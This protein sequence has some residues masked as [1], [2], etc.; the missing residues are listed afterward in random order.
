M[1]TILLGIADVLASVFTQIGQY[2]HV[3]TIT[4]YAHYLQKNPGIVISLVVTL[5]FIVLMIESA[6]GTPIPANTRAKP[7]AE[8]AMN[9]ISIA[10]M[11]GEGAGNEQRTYPFNAVA[12]D[13]LVK[14]LKAGIKANPLR[15]YR[16]LIGEEQYLGSETS[17]DARIYLTRFI[18]YVISNKIDSHRAEAHRQFQKCYTIEG[19]P[20]TPAPKNEDR[21]IEQLSMQAAVGAVAGAAMAEVMI[22]ENRR[23][24]GREEETT[25]YEV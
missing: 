4:N 11:A 20:I 14:G 17:E 13:I 9:N 25:Y 16:T 1:D 10:C 24:E 12:H 15:L 23:K 18:R 7:P 3:A 21:L 2:L 5:A 19:V 22:K 8:A 6:T